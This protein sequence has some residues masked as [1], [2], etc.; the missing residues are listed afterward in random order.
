MAIELPARRRLALLPTPLEAVDRLSEE[1]GGPRIWVKRDDLT[2][3]GLSGNKVR[4]LEFHFAAAEAAG[5]DTVITCGATQSNHSRATALAGARLGVRVILLLRHDD[6]TQPPQLKANFLLDTLAGAEIRLITPQEWEHRDQLMAAAAESER[7]AGHRC[8]VIPEGASD[9][10]GMWGFVI[11]MRELA[12]QLAAVPGSPAVI[13]HGASSGGTTAGIGW[14]VDRLGLDLDV[15]ACS[16]GDSADDIRGKVEDIWR[17]ACEATGAAP[18]RAAIEY[19]DRH[20]GGGYGVVSSDELAIQAQATAL[21]GLILDPTYTGKALAGLRREIEA[22]RYTATDNIVFWH[23][24]GGFAA[25]A[26]DFTGIGVA[27]GRAVDSD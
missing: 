1:W 10:M 16:I 20:I 27:A 26:H 11:A 21:T 19:N 2:G 13:W 17:Q 25:F 18:P 9:P 23:T 6:P 14:A 3:F 24:G 4:K 22:G 12:D 7:A 15:V 8:W 5:A